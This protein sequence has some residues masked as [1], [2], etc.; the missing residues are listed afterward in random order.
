MTVAADNG[1]FGWVAALALLSGAAV[2]IPSLVALAASLV[3]VAA[4][5]L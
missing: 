3:A 4:A 1:K 5:L 2:I